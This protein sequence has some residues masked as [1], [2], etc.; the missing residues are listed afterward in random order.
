M[1]YD[2]LFQLGAEGLYVTKIA[3]LAEV[4]NALTD[5]GDGVFG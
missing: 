2:F 1:I 3:Y 4:T 5:G